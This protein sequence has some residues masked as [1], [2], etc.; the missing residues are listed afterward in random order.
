[1]DSVGG[2]VR[3]VIRYEDSVLKIYLFFWGSEFFNLKEIGFLS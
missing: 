3:F 2:F 1:M